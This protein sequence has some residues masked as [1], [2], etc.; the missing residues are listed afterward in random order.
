MGTFQGMRGI[1][2]YKI[3]SNAG[4][5]MGEG[6]SWGTGVHQ[7]FSGGCFVMSDEFTISDGY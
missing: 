4:L 3:E 5:V 2:G 6:G 1:R 7:M